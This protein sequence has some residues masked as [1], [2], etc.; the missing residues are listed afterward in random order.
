MH[1]EKCLTNKALILI[2]SD[3]ILLLVIHL[4]K[5]AWVSGRVGWMKLLSKHFLKAINQ[6]F[7]KLLHAPLEIG[8]NVILLPLVPHP[9]VF[10]ESTKVLDGLLF[11]NLCLEPG[12]SSLGTN[13]ECI[14]NI[15]DN[16]PFQFS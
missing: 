7:P 11:T 4:E 14:I 16:N 5:L 8:T 13:E 1:V 3:W 15:D 10:P 12:D 2:K 6:A 9:E